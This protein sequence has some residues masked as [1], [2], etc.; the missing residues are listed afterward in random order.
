M[1]T[2]FYII[3]IV[4]DYHIRF[5]WFWF[6][7]SIIFSLAEEGGRRIYRYTTDK[8]LEGHEEEV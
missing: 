8:S 7:I 2:L 4:F 6:I 3:L 5:N 1:A